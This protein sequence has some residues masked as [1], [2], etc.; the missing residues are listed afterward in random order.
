MVTYD[1]LMLAILVATVVWGLYKGMAWQIA[2]VASLVVSY[3]V[4]IELRE[5]VA[6]AL[7]LEPPW[8]NLA[9]M[10]GLYLLTSLVIWMLFS[11]VKKTLDQWELKDW[12]RQVGAGI[13]LIKGLLLCII[14]T[15]FAVAMTKD[16]NRQHIVASKSGFYITKVIHQLHSVMPDEVNSVVE[17][18]IIRYNQRING[19]DP[20]WFADVDGPGDSQGFD[21]RKRLQDFRNDVQDR[22]QGRVQVEVQ[23]Q[24]NQF[25]N[26]V[27][28]AIENPQ[29]AESNWR[30][31]TGQYGQ[32]PGGGNYPPRMNIPA[33]ALPEGSSWVPPYSQGSGPS[34]VVPQYPQQAP[35]Y[36]R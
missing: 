34:P 4:S 35:A 23:N 12:D 29:E 24:T 27:Q 9:A 14:V 6:K 15:M 36:G 3:L 16:A 7:G 17:P 30:Q 11:L 5:P 22:V 2:S 28:Q 19:Q 13:G 8:G 32:Q 18:Y 25:Q 10:L 1:F 33:P 21:L 20:D 26:F 31:Y